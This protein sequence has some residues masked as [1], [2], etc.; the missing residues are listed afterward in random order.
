MSYH[1]Y[2]TDAIILKKTAFGEANLLLHILTKDLGLIMAS[3]RSA[4]LSVSKLRPGLQ[5]FSVVSVSCIKSKNGWKI[6]NVSVKENIFFSYPKHFHN[7][8]A[9]ISQLLIK[10][11]QGEHPEP[12]LYKVVITGFEYLKNIQEKN[13]ENIEVVFVLRILYILGYVDDKEDV[14]AFIQDLYKWDDE[15]IEAVSK[16]KKNIVAIIN[17]AL[18]A[19]QL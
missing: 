7:I 12:N 5:E 3:A 15:V 8:L 17:K 18:K 16:D 14:K 4:R 19:S 1:I 10:M 11:V 2:T 13:I 6:T 9:R